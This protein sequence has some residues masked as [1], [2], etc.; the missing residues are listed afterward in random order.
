MR[1]VRLLYR[2]PRVV[3]VP[4]SA[5]Q[6]GD[7]AAIKQM[8]Y[9]KSEGGRRVVVAEGQPTSLAQMQLQ[10]QCVLSL[11]VRVPR[12]LGAVNLRLGPRLALLRATALT[13]C[14][15]PCRL[16]DFNVQLFR[17]LLGGF[18]PKIEY[19]AGLHETPGLSIPVVFQSP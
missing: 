9:E 2:H 12:C 17:E 10:N 1:V 5:V 4:M 18:A 7:V 16:I 13:S 19:A 6:G 8:L 11:L 15:R 14:P 3:I